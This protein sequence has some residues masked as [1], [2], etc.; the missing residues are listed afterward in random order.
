MCRGQG[1]GI[2][3]SIYVRHQEF[4]GISGLR[5][6]PQAVLLVEGRRLV[7]R[8]QQSVYVLSE[9]VG[10]ARRKSVPWK[11]GVGSG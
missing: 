1:D 8:V 2:S 9:Q 3:G 4:K 11:L 7:A 10:I 6:H 5:L